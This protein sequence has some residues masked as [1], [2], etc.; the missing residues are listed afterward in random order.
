MFLF[1]QFIVYQNQQM[2]GCQIPPANRDGTFSHQE[3]GFSKLNPIFWWLNT[4][5]GRA[6]IKK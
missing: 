6:I 2:Y 3:I 1:Y 5:G 4:I